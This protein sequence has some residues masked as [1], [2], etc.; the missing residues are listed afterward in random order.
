MVT[1]GNFKIGLTHGHQVVPWGDLESLAVVSSCALCVCVC[2]HACVCIIVCVYMHYV[3]ACVCTYVYIHTYI[4]YYY[5]YICVMC[6]VHVCIIVGQTCVT[7][8]LMQ[9]YSKLFKEA[10]APNIQNMLVC[11]LYSSNDNIRV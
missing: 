10:G 4:H 9:N 7:M 8:D 3:Y 11:S 5:T 2:V 6:C 1:V